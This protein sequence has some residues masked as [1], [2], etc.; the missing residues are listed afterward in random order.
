MAI[1]F[2]NLVCLAAAGDPACTRVLRAVSAHSDMVGGQD[3]YCTDMMQAVQGRAIGKLG[4]DGIYCMGIPERGW[5]VAIK[6]DDGAT[7]PQYNVAQGI[8]NALGICSASNQDLLADYLDTPIRNCKGVCTGTRSL[9]PEL[10]QA[11]HGL[12]EK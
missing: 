10:V 1:G 12:P 5:G 6:I 3:R 2:K 11:L 8:L 9:D 7:G 4:A